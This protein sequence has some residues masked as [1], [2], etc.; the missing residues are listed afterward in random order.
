MSA[1][2]FDAAPLLAHLA[3]L[4]LVAGRSE[5]SMFASEVGR[6]EVLAMAAIAG[7]SPRT[8]HRWRRGGRVGLRV[9]DRVAITLNLHPVLLWPH[10]YEADGDLLDEAP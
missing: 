5:F 7:V 4:S 1:R 3:P 2:S 6:P 10:F 9:A 8:V